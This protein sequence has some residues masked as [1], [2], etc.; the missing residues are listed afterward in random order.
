MHMTTA[1]K[2]V[3]RRPVK[4][5]AL[6]SGTISA[7]WYDEEQADKSS[8]KRRNTIVLTREKTGDQTKPHYDA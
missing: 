7:V 3:T 1:K 5:S 8:A 4:Y 6:S 2:T